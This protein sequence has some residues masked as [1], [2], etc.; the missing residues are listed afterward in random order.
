MKAATASP[1]RCSMP[2][3]AWP[4]LTL[5]PDQELAAGQP[6]LEV[7]LAISDLLGIRGLIRR[8]LNRQSGQA[9]LVTDPAA[10]LPSTHLLAYD[11]GVLDGADAVAIGHSSLAS[12]HAV[13]V[14][15]NGLTLT[16][17]SPL[18]VI[19]VV[20]GT[21]SGEIARTGALPFREQ[22]RRSSAPRR[23]AQPA[24]PIGVIRL[25][26]GLELPVT[27][28]YNS[29]LG[30]FGWRAGDA[31]RIPLS[32]GT[33]GPEGEMELSPNRRFNRKSPARCPACVRWP[34]M[35]AG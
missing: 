16:M 23:A 26:G 33:A 5:D 29:L 35:W 18:G 34:V 12:V 2:T 14:T 32:N 7:S 1:S 20:S 27:S 17:P 9:W 3:A 15:R 21:L 30:H 8:R 25:R 28:M 10:M 24:T 11:D 4:N 31:G 19:E 22:R 13:P 6:P